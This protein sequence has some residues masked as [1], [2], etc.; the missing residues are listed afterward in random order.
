MKSIIIKDISDEL[1][2]KV[3]KLQADLNA[4]TWEDFLELIVAKLEKG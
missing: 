2:F 4:K 3:K 1:Y